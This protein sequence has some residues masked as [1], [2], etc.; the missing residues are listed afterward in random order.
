MI[1]QK[2]LET[3]TKVETKTQITFF[4]CFFLFFEVGVVLV[5]VWENLGWIAKLR[6]FVRQ[7]LDSVLVP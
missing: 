3:F 1:F 4:F 7:D 6:E 2:S 5:S